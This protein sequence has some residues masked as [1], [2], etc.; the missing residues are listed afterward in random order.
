MATPLE[1]QFKI[2]KTVYSWVMPETEALIREVQANPKFWGEI[3]NRHREAWTGKQDAYHEEFFETWLE[4]T[5]GVVNKPTGSYY[6][7]TAGSSEA[8][9]ESLA[10]MA[11]IASYRPH[12]GV[13][14]I[15]V[16]GGEYEGYKAL[17]EPYGIHVVTHDRAQWEEAVDKIA[18]ST[19]K[20][21]GHRFYISQPSSINGCMWQEFPD[22]LDLVASTT[23]A[24][25]MLDIC[26]VG[27]VPQDCYP[28]YKIPADH[29]VIDT[30]FFSLS[31]VFGLYYHRVGGMITHT[32]H[33]GL[34][35]NKWF[36]NLTSLY[37]GT[38]FMQT[39]GVTELP[40]KYRDLQHE[41]IVDIERGDTEGIFNPKIGSD[42]IASD[43]F[44]L[45]TQT[46]SFPGMLPNTFARTPHYNRY[47]LTCRLYEKCKENGMYE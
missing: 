7:P 8:I 34:W 19:H 23:E 15:H 46:S 27:T 30:V 11:S 20:G 21:R 2:T 41:V 28:D 10:Q 25:V 35:G 38:S 18:A 22:F 6:Y 12:L 5:S 4:W 24:K 43:V 9:R 42:M 36:K 14:T 39:H 1:E 47:C 13:P 45:A 37:L 33:P 44:L 17:A 29:E 32:E 16:F 31:K 26:Y 3:Q 40:D